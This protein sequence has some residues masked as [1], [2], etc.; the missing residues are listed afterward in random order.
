MEDSSSARSR[1]H[2]PSGYGGAIAALLTYL[3]YKDKLYPESFDAHFILPYVR[4]QPFL[5][6]SPTMRAQLLAFM[7]S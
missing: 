5:V 2:S 1:K 7:L 6:Y 3:S 4:I